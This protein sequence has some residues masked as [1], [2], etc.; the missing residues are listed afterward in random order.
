M[1]KSE[2]RIPKFE[3]SNAQNTLYFEFCSFEFVLDLVLR[4]LSL[5]TR[6][7]LGIIILFMRIIRCMV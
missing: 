1:E 3:R 5:P 4:I 6:S 2:Y 7:A